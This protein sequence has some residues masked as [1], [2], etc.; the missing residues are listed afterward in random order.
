MELFFKSNVILLLHS[1]S[2]HIIFFC[3]CI[4]FHSVCI[5]TRFFLR[6]PY[7]K[8]VLT[9]YSQTIKCIT[10]KSVLF[11]YSKYIEY[12]ITAT[13]KGGHCI[14]EENI[15]HQNHDKFYLN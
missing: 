11:L 10:K 3:L 15:K 7:S 12:K 13:D 14:N 2:F 1:I 8:W 4:L 6:F 5:S 9:I